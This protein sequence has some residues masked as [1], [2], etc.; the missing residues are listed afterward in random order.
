[1]QARLNVSRLLQQVQELYPPLPPSPP[2]SPGASPRDGA[3]ESPPPLRP[4]P[5]PR[6]ARP[7]PSP[8]VSPSPAPLPCRGV[9]YDGYL[10]SCTVQFLAAGGQLLF[11]SNTSNGSF[12]AASA[13]AGSV[14]RA[15]LVP[16]A[17][18]R[19]SKGEAGRL[20]CRSVLLMGI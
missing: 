15:Q 14:R 7:S 10:H 13:A 17:E 6:P 5:S 2:P 8:R 11:A 9:A 4:S 20:K 16:A 1:M 18:G 3:A 19:V 12:S